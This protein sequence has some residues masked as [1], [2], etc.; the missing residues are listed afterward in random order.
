MRGEAG[1]KQV[2]HADT[3]LMHV[4]GTGT[5]PLHGGPHVVVVVVVVFF[6]EGRGG[7]REQRGGLGSGSRTPC[8][9]RS[10]GSGTCSVPMRWLGLYAQHDE[11][12]GPS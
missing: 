8:Q 2:E 12:R 1:Y 10:C 5:L 6:G 7:R 11:I 4:I 3:L 9:S